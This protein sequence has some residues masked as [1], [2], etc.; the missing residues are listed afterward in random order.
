MESQR[1]MK[2][3]KQH[4]IPNC[5]LKAWC[6]PRTPPGRHSFIWRISKHG[7]QRKRKSPEKSFTASERYTIRLP[8]G[9]RNLALEDTL[10]GIEDRFVLVLKRVRRQ[11]RL[12]PVDRAGLCIFATGM[13]TR[14][15]AFGEHWNKQLQELHDKV[16][17]L[18]KA[19]NAEPTTSTQTAELLEHAQ[20]HVIVMSLPTVTPLLF[21]MPMT[22]LV[23]NDELGFIT[24]DNPCV[25]FNPKW[26]K[27]PPFFRSPGLAQTDIEITL[28][29]TPQHVLLISHRTYPLYQRVGQRVVDELNR[30]SRFFCTEEFVSWKGETRPYWFDPGKEPEDTWEKSEEGNR[31]LAERERMMQLE[32]EEKEQK[33]PNKEAK[34]DPGPDR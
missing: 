14:T 8:N 9:K 20:Q 12:N 29:L 27:L 18:E 23:T 13:L 32:G 3:K 17:A 24:S 31:A 30:R 21:Q 33:E 16:V 4:V 5:Y 15:T 7:T 1:E 11:Q 26:Y 22:I 28:P 10:A 19:H 25:L 6:D 34:Q 2:K